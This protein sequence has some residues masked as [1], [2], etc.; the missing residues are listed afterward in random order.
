MPLLF[1]PFPCSSCF[2]I[3]G[4]LAEGT[5]KQI[6]VALSQLLEAEGLSEKAA[7]AA[8]EEVLKHSPSTDKDCLIQLHDLKLMFATLKQYGVKTAICTSDCRPN[9]I[10]S[11]VEMELVS[12][13]DKVSIITQ[14]VLMLGQKARL[15]T[16]L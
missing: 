7:V 8:V 10:R 13:V 6:K 9:T 1:P 3:V 12:L 16:F 15:D 14:T 4:L 5:S 2:G 11:L